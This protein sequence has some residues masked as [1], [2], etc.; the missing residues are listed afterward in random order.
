VPFAWQLP[1]LLL[2]PAVVKTRLITGILMALGAIALL[3]YAPPI[4]TYVL[5]QVAAFIVGDEFYRITLGADRTRER[6]AGMIA[7]AITVA[8]AWWG[9]EPQ[10]MAAMFV[11]TPALLSVVLFT[12]ATVQDMGPRAGLLLGGYAYLAIP[13][14]AMTLIVQWNQGPMIV[15]AL[16]AA[17][18]SGDSGA[19][20]AG[21]FL[22]NKKLYEKISP[23]KTWA[24]AYGG[25]VA[26][27]I[28][29]YIV[30]TLAGLPFEPVVALLLGLACGVVGQVGDL[31]ESLFKRAYNVKDSGTLLPG[32]GGLLDRVDGVLFS[33]PVLWAGVTLFVH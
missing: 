30:T 10:L 18:F 5:F 25:A 2:D 17:V 12:D 16:F 14:A 11:L 13:M 33:A 20:F 32:H 4:A 6:Y 28:G 24:G 3:T 26:S 27:A 29:F 15:L 9:T 1:D 19:F 23:K 22:G 31:A 7:I 21:K 8:A